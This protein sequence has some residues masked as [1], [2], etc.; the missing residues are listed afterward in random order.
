MEDCQ[1]PTTKKIPLV[2]IKSQ[3]NVTDFFYIRGIVHYE[4]VSTGQTIKQIYSFEV[5]EKLR[6]KLDGNDPKFLPI[7]LESCI[8]TKHLLTQHCL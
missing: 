5:L 3:N 6:K 8:T 7:T 2:Q 4:F 1:F